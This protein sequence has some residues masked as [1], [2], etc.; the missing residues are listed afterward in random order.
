MAERGLRGLDL[1]DVDGRSNYRRLVS[2]GARIPRGGR[3]RSAAAQA[4]RWV[5]SEGQSCRKFLTSESILL[6]SDPNVRNVL[7][8][9][10]K[11]CDPTRSPI[12]GESCS[13]I[14]RRFSALD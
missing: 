13:S 6:K 5:P 11:I 3:R 1:S 7:V 4:A 12:K 14:R 2:A 9:T 10:S 8:Q